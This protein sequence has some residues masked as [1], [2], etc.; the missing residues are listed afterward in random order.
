MRELIR[1]RGNCGIERL[2]GASCPEDA[3]IAAAIVDFQSVVLPPV[4]VAVALAE[5]PVPA[6]QGRWFYPS[7]DG[8]GVA[9]IDRIAVP[10][11]YGIVR[12]IESDAIPVFPGVGPDASVAQG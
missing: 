11:G 7:L 9:E 8:A 1:H 6:V 3:D 10:H 12:S 4:V 5:N 2:G